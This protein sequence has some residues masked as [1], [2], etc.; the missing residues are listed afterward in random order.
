[1]NIVQKWI[2]VTGVGGFIGSHLVEELVRLGAAVRAFVHYNYR[3]DWGHL[4][5]LPP[6]IKRNLEIVTG[7]VADSRCV[8]RAMAGCGTVFHLAALIGIP[9]SY[10]APESYVR[11]NIIGTLNVLNAALGSGTDNVLE[12]SLVV[13]YV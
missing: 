12:E 6:E 13:Q 5:T 9:Y 2:L 10:Q 1:M 11:T 7:D 8:D 3:N 4:E